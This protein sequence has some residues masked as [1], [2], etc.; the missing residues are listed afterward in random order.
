MKFSCSQYTFDEIWLHIFHKWVLGN[1]GTCHEFDSC[2]NLLCT[3]AC[4]GK[5]SHHLLVD[6]SLEEAEVNSLPGSSLLNFE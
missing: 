2:C 5:D 3:V 1:Q 6:E 4:L